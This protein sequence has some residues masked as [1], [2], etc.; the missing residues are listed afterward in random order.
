MV[1]EWLTRWRAERARALGPAATLDAAR[2]RMATSAADLTR[3]TAETADASV[4]PAVVLDAQAIYWVLVALRGERLPTFSEQWDA[5]DPALLADAAQD[6]AEL[7]DLRALLVDSSFIELADFPDDG[8]RAW[9]ERTRIFRDRLVAAVDD[10]REPAAR[11]ALQRVIQVALAAVAVGL[12]VLFI[13]SAI[14][15]R[16]RGP[17]LARGKPWRASS[18]LEDCP[19]GVTRRCVHWRLDIFFHTKEEPSPWIEIDLRAPTTISKV[20]VRNRL[21][22]CWDRAV[23]LV[24]EVAES[25]LRYREVARQEDPFDEIVLEFAPTTAR[26]VRL[27]VEKTSAL[28]L[29][30]VS[31][32][33]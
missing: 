16:G 28:H 8:L 24:V 21:D 29:E 3:E 26:Y 31:V 25:R 4:A 7:E 23:P 10:R 15:S 5:A 1:A 11:L 27:R 12:V 2:A 22:C 32:Y 6:L 13:A 14:I 9:A 33:R 19:L 20:V 18:A 17:D 30:R